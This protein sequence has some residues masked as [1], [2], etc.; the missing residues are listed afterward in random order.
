[1]LK[2]VF[3]TKNKLTAYNYKLIRLLAVDNN[4]EIAAVIVDCFK[5]KPKTLSEKIS[6]IV[7]CDKNEI[8]FKVK[9]KI[10]NLF[11]EDNDFQNKFQKLQQE[12]CLNIVYVDDIN[13]DENIKKIKSLEADLGIIS[14]SRIL[15]EGVVKSPRLGCLNIHKRKLPDYRGGGAPFYWEAINGESEIAVTIHYAEA[16][17]DSGAILAEQKISIGKYENLQSAKLKVDSIGCFLY[18]DTI[19]EFIQ[20]PPIGISQDLSKGNEF[21]SA[22]EFEEY[23]LNQKLLKT[24]NTMPRI[25]KDKCLIIDKFIKTSKYLL[26]YPFLYLMRQRLF[27]RKEVPIIIF[28]Y[29]TVGNNQVNATT[30][31]LERFAEQVNYLKKRYEIISLCEARK[32]IAKGENCQP[33]VVITFDDGYAEDFAGTIPFLRANDIPATFFVSVGSCCENKNFAHDTNKGFQ[34]DLLNSEQIKQI[35]DWGFEIGSHGIYH[36]DINDLNL[37]E[38]ESVFSKSKEMIETI[39][40]KTCSAFA[41][42]YGILYKNLNCENQQIASRIYQETCH[43]WGGYNYPQKNK[44]NKLPFLR[45]SAPNTV[46]E[47]SHIMNGYTGVKNTLLGNAFGLADRDILKQF[48]VGK[49]K[50]IAFIETGSGL[51]GS[52]YSLLRILQIIKNDYS[53]VITPVVVVIAEQAKNAFSQKGFKTILIAEKGFMGKVNVFRKMLKQE[54]IDCVHCNNPPYEHIPFII[55]AKSR[56]LDVTLHFRVSRELTLAEK[57]IAKFVK[58]IFSVSLSGETV[59]KKSLGDCYPVTMLGDGV[60]LSEYECVASKS[61]RSELGIDN[62]FV[63][64]LPSTLQAG[65]GQDVTILAAKKIKDK[66]LNVKWIFAGSEHYQAVGFRSELEKIII[67]HS[68]ENDVKIIGHR[69]DIPELLSLSDLVI[70]PSR[71]T[72]GMPCVI[73]EAFAAGKPVIASSCGGMGEAVSDKTGELL[74]SITPDA[75]A[76]VVE[77]FYLDK[78]LL[79]QKASEAKEKAIND[80]DIEKITKKMLSIILD[81]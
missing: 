13:S 69:D 14:G 29:H 4:I 62:A 70:M 55:A 43:A 24:T 51:G 2:V 22:S 27:K 49:V 12:F 76:D 41:F 52:T 72:E 45:I 40:G 9:Q 6:K 57:F 25:A 75:I 16:E 32:R 53:A 33:A 81:S 58:H 74:S 67:K 10:H 17:V 19:K 36:E 71:L 56:L 7:S 35:S 46:G 18:F 66:G 47:I 64:I 60:I 31:P 34:L 26:C 54:N 21:F 15:K 28:Y 30:L 59:I 1:M 38:V 61:L 50:K 73:L 79:L 5:K 63:I 42:P 68:L 44:D 11:S 65:K 8:A 39:T 37:K 80:Y 20:N 77:R 23:R 48:L 78:D 3:F